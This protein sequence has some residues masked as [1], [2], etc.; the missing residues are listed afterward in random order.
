M[1]TLVKQMD[2][3]VDC[4]KPITAIKKWNETIK[5]TEYEEYELT[6]EGFSFARQHNGFVVKDVRDLGYVQGIEETA[7]G[8]YAWINIYSNR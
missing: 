8:F 6:T 4:K 2:L 1:I 5:G 7:N 3:M